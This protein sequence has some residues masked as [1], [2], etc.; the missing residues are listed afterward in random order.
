M[1]LLLASCLSLFL[2]PAFANAASQVAVTSETVADSDY[3][4]FTGRTIIGSSLE[5][6]RSIMTDAS[7]YPSILHKC[8]AASV[9]V[10]ANGDP[11]RE[12][13]FVFYGSE[14]SGDRY[15]IL[16]VAQRS[17]HRAFRIDLRDLPS[18]IPPVAAERFVSEKMARMKDVTGFWSF[19]EIDSNS[20]EITYS[21]YIDYI[22]PRIRNSDLPLGG[23]VRFLPEIDGHI[24]RKV[25]LYVEELVR[26]S[27]TNLRETA[28]GIM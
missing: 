3:R 20:V 10:G 9:L 17:D 1:S 11:L 5:R 18:P 12:I 16:E 2:P 8:P 23:L 4:R 27:V 19:A 21:L 24:A 6:L 14:R 25:N 22:D 28:L 13:F 15:M 26:Q 7:L